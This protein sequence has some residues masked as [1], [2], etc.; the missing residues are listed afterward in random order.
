MSAEISD[1]RWICMMK[2]RKLKI[3]LFF[4]ATLYSRHDTLG[5]GIDSLDW[6]IRYYTV[7]FWLVVCRYRCQSP[8]EYRTGC[9][10]T[11]API[12]IHSILKLY[13]GR[14]ITSTLYTQTVFQHQA[15]DIPQII[16]YPV[17]QKVHRHH[18]HRRSMHDKCC[19][20]P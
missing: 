10:C 5:C 18:D 11:Q 16:P 1:N 15:S 2:D 4:F 19:R 8:D 20:L 13:P 7:L 17:M 12:P 9:V 6:L 3:M 14:E